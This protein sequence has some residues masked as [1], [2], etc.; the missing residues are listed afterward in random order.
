MPLTITFHGLCGLADRGSVGYEVFAHPGHGDHTAV[1]AATVAASVDVVQ[2]TWLPDVVTNDNNGDQVG[3]W[4]LAGLDLSFPSAAIGSIPWAA[5][6]SSLDLAVIHRPP[7]TTSSKATIRGRL[8]QVAV[9]TLP[10]GQL[11]G[12]LSGTTQ[13][14]DASG[15]I[16]PAPVNFPNVP[17]EIIWSGADFSGKDLQLVSAKG[18]LAFK[19]DAIARVTCAYS[20]SGMANLP[21]HF[22]FFYDLIDNV[23]ATDDVRVTPHMLA[24]WAAI[25]PVYDCV[26]PT[27]MP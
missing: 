19:D 14:L 23:P 25:P 10:R 20:G 17:D 18:V 27:P 11:R 12:N 7:A 24:R 5:R 22:L 15:G 26:P 8:R 21:Q 2:T 3:Y 9:L 4:L 13:D 6:A 1:L 16:L